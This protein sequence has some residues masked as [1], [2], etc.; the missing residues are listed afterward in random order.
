MRIAFA[1]VLVAAA[2]SYRIWAT[3]D[4]A[5]SNFSPLMAITFCGGVYFRR[6]WMWLIPFVAL[7]LSDVYINHY[8]A[9]Q[10]GYEF[11]VSGVLART[12]CFAAALGLGRWVRGRKSWLWLL[13]GSILGALLF[14]LVTNS[15]SWLADPYYPRTL[16]GWWQA[17]TVGHPEFPPTIAFFLK[18]LFGDLT[19]TGLFAGLLE[20]RAQSQGEPSLLDGGEEEEDGEEPAEETVEA[21]VK[22]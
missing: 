5:L 8:Y 11:P 20:W 21:E 4:F 7:S 17:M 3:G 10:W 13:N 22:E 14:Y 15:Q 19:F 1:L 9:K 6:W 12:A 16:A 2:L 18:S